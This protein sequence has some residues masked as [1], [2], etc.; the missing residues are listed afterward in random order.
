[1]IGYLG[2]TG[3]LEG[4]TSPRRLYKRLPEAQDVPNALTRSEPQE[5]VSDLTQEVSS[6]INNLIDVFLAVFTRHSASSFYLA[7]GCGVNAKGANHRK[8]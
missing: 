5:V 1:V 6:T 7:T 3:V 4:G 8:W 2:L